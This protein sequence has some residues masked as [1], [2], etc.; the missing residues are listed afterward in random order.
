MVLVTF[1]CREYPCGSLKPL[2]HTDRLAA[3]QYL[4][5]LEIIGEMGKAS[6]V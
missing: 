6:A 4:M 1:D 5:V 2:V 3:I